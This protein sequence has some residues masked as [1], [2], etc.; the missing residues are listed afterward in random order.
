MR[1]VSLAAWLG[2]FAWAA[3]VSPRGAAEERSPA[4]PAKPA[5]GVVFG[6]PA[7]RL[8]EVACVQAPLVTGALPDVVELPLLG[9]PTSFF[10]RSWMCPMLPALLDMLERRLATTKGAPAIFMLTPGDPSAVRAWLDEQRA[11]RGSVE[12]RWPRIG[13]GCLAPGVF[14]LAYTRHSGISNG[15]AMWLCDAERRLM[16]VGHPGALFSVLDR[17]RAKTW[18]ASAMAGRQAVRLAEFDRR[19]RL[20]RRIETMREARDFTGLVELIEFERMEEPGMRMQR[21]FYMLAAGRADGVDALRVEGVTDPML[22]LGT[23]TARRMLDDPHLV[24]RDI[25]LALECATAGVET[26]RLEHAEACF[27]L[28][29]TLL[30]AGRPSEGTGLVDEARRLAGDIPGELADRIR[31]FKLPEA[32]PPV[33]E[34]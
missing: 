7:P 14:E 11:P 26:A 4:E 21:A 8:L 9:R 23:Y 34:R 30:A 17:V 22:A 19:H 31:L 3:M 16:W 13:F 28:G 24:V 20:N 12:A 33:S 10:R 15:V 25:P 6:E 27:T 5:A 29:R 32:E 2:A 1:R 18:D